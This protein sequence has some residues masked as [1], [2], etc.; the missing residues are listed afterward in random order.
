VRVA[1]ERE[2][3]RDL[4]ETEQQARHA[5][6]HHNGAVS[7]AFLRGYQAGYEQA[8]RDAKRGK[9]HRDRAFQPNIGR[10]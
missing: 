3:T 6:L 5:R 10:R 8:I 7:L 9:L 1:I 4:R 2:S